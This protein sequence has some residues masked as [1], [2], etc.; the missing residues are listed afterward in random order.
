M[1]TPHNFTHARYAKKGEGYELSSK[2]DSRFS[3]LYCR[4]KD[5]RTIE[6]A[7]QLDVKGYRVEGNDWKLGKGK[8]AINGKTPDQ[9]W[10]AY[11]DLW[12]QWTQENPAQLEDL[13][14]KAAGK[15]LTDM[16][17]SSPVSQA[18]ALALIL[19]ETGPNAAPAP[20]DTPSPL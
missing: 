6:Q 15:I 5:G 1:S 12:R 19:N 11:L 8:P 2:G 10:D 7:Y 13:R 17:A 4:L 16:F 9:L 18:R 14:A 3:A 20:T